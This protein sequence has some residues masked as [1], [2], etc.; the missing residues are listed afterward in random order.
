[1]A[2]LLVFV[3][4]LWGLRH[5]VSTAHFTFLGPKRCNVFILACN[6]YLHNYLKIV[7]D[8]LDQNPCNNFLGFSAQWRPHGRQL[9]FNRRAPECLQHVFFPKFRSHIIHFTVFDVHSWYN[10]ISS[11]VS[12]IGVV[13]PPAP[14]EILIDISRDPFMLSVDVHPRPR[15]CF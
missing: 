4:F 3:A 13:Q 8:F 10:E 6:M 5:R 1:M 9:F 12:S 2:L 7:D 11:S 15:S 14:P